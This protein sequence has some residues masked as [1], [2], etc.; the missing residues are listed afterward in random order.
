MDQEFWSVTEIIAELDSRLKVA[1]ELSM[2]R[3]QANV[4]F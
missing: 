1:T 3:T 4:T 2:N